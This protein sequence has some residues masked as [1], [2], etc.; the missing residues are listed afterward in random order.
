MN[1][2]NNFQ[3]FKPDYELERSKLQNFLK[4]F[5]DRNIERD[6]VHDQRKYMIELV[7]SNFNIAK[8]CK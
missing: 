1:K 4:T 7:Y 5:V 8:N 6:R 2:P 3:T